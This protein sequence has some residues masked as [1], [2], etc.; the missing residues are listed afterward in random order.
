MSG[1]NRIQIRHL[2]LSNMT[3]NETGEEKGRY[4]NQKR[5]SQVIQ[6]TKEKAKKTGSVSCIEL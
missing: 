3:V 2:T 6:Q 5:T 4:S 1:P